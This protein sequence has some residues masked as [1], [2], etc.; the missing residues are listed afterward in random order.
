MNAQ[1]SNP[2]NFWRNGSLLENNNIL[3]IPNEPDDNNRKCLIINKVIIMQLE[4]NNILKSLTM[5]LK[6]YPSDPRN[7]L[8]N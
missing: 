8:P 7:S 3:S 2:E 6:I 1:I 4:I 5:P